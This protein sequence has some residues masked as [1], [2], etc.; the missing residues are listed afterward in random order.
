M[1]I[2]EVIATFPPYHGGMGYVCYHNS[3][4]LARRG[5]DVT[6]FTLEHG[7]MTYESDP[8]EFRIVRLRTHLLYGDGG[9]VPQL[10]A[11][12]KSFD[13]VH[14]HYPFFGGAEYVYLAS[15]VH[16]SKYF[17]TYHMDV[18]GTTFFKKLLITSYTMLFL[19]H[20]IRKAALIGAVTR[21]H[22]KHSQ[23]APFVDWNK[24][25][26]MPNGVDTTVFCPREKK[27][28]LIDQYGLTDETVVLF[29]GNLQ[30]F[31]GLNILI[32]A[33]AMM[34]DRR[35]VLIIV[36][37]GYCE[38][39]YRKQV[40]DKGLQN[41]IIFA[42][43]QAPDKDL[44]HYY[45]LCDFLVLPSTYSESFGLVVLEAMASGKPAI[46]SSLPGPSQLIEDGTDGL[47][48]K[49]GDVEDLKNK[50][51]YLSNNGPLRRD[52][53]QAARGKIMKKYGWDTIGEQLEKTFEAIMIQ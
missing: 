47:I 46:V 19:R 53:G 40:I 8:P 20:M 4:Q 28:A 16:G 5:H 25:V 14:L 42:G 13:I 10:Y 15:L 38:A 39:E 12:L 50:V 30:P 18:H 31:K 2:A 51:E 29:V 37:G 36:G 35:I 3:L 41:T 9:V 33:M 7:R 22:L 26:D 45:N 52:M 44:P 48:A 49:V 43:P 34:K 21:E 32:D 23:A 24:V 1:K 17:L 11:R 27:Q 6:V